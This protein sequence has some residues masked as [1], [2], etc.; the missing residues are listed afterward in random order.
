[1][2]PETL[3]LYFHIPFCKRKCPY[4]DFYSVLYNKDLA[5]AYVQALLRAIE[6]APEGPCGPVDSVYFGGGTPAL[7]SAGQ[8]LRLLEAAAGRYRF[9]PDCEITLEANPAVLTLE[10]LQQLKQGG[11]TRVSMGVQSAVEGQLRTLGRLHSVGEAQEAVALCRQAGFDNV[12]VDLML[13]TPG[14]RPEDVDAFC[15]IFCPQVE[16]VS[17]YLLKIE[18]G[19]PF[20][21]QHMER[22]CPGE[23]EA[24]DLYLRAVEQLASWGFGQY[25]ISNFCRPGRESRHNS[26]YWRL[27]PYL[28]F[29][30]AAHSF[31]QGQRAYFPRDL[32]GFIAREDPWQL[33]QPDGPGGDFFEYVMLGLRLQEGIAFEDC[34]RRYPEVD[35]S[36]LKKQA[37]LLQSHGLAR[38]DEKGLALTLQGFLVSNA[39]IGRLL[40]AYPEG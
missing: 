6:K 19:T 28:G 11:F 3:G 26:R 24:A 1:M 14:Q 30:P 39:A 12:S 33:W 13:A 16:H 25:E 17:A 18:E 21:R 10:Q 31:W 23:D 37:A 4:C 32:L 9:T 7:L 29:G 34:A 22:R 8:L 35:L 36:P 27:A 20:G 15:R 38:L 40:D 5:E 2:S